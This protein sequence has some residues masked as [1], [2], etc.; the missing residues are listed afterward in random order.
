MAKTSMRETALCE[1]LLLQEH[2]A[3]LKQL[4]TFESI[5]RKPNKYGEQAT[6]M[7]AVKKRHHT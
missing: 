6:T 1:F 2:F 7:T 3:A 5:N 4:W